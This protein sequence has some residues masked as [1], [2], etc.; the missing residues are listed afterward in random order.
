MSLKMTITASGQQPF[1]LAQSGMGKII[2]GSNWPNGA[3]GPIE[4]GFLPRLAYT[5]QPIKP[6][7]AAFAQ[8]KSRFNLQFSE[9]FSVTRTFQTTSACILFLATHLSLVPAN[10]VMILNFSGPDGPVLNLY[11]PATMEGIDTAWHIGRSCKLTYRYVGD[12]AGWSTV[13]PNAV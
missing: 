2:M 4:D 5:N 3:G 7:R 8:N 10:G 11:L 6:N 9:Q 1:T 13:N 12:G